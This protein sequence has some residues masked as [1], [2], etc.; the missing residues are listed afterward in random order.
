MVK[1]LKIAISG[2]ASSGKDTLSEII[3][4]Q[5]WKEEIIKPIQSIKIA[6]A[7]PVKEIASTMFP[8]IPLEYFYGSS[9][10]RDNIIPNAFKNGNPL[11][12]RQLLLDIGTSGRLYNENIW[13]NNFN[14][15]L[16]ELEDQFNVVICSDGRFINEINYLRENNF[17]LIRLYRD[18]NKPIINHISETGQKNIQ[19]NEFDYVLYN[20]KG[21]FDLKQNVK[22]N[23]L[24]K[25]KKHFDFA[26]I[27]AYNSEH[28]F[29]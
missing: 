27:I 26:D 10:H 18:T 2:L 11:S 21:L 8:A 23:L 12:I 29:P 3:A 16:K 19:D 15:R 22:Y 5:L 9:R 14:N 1:Q 17:F 24:P 4:D 28:N 13:I 7:T 20:D 25:L 6:F